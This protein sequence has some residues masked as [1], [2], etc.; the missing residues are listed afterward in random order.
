M[1]DNLDFLTKKISKFK[2]HAKEV[3]FLDE[4][5]RSLFLVIKKSDILEKYHTFSAKL[6]SHHQAIFEP[7]LSLAYGFHSLSDKK[8][9]INYIGKF[10]TEIQIKSLCLAFNNELE[11]KWRIVKSNNLN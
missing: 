5:F 2:I 11:L 7:H 9:M 3:G 10:P 8:K 1:I 6:I 4:K